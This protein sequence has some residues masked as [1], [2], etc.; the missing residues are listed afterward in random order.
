M[1]HMPASPQSRNG[2]D[3][4]PDAT[5]SRSTGHLFVSVVVCKGGKHQLTGFTLLESG[6]AVERL[7]GLLANIHDP[8][9]VT[10]HIDFTN[11]FEW[12]QDLPGAV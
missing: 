3:C 8:D 5:N 4:L 6:A 1:T 10:R 2:L 11:W 9:Y 7:T 12:T